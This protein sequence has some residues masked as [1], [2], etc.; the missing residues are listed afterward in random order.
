LD[1]GDSNQSGKHYAGVSSLQMG[2]DIEEL[3][4]RTS[5]YEDKE[6]ASRI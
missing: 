2:P 4:V 6:E 1:T 3:Q 5:G